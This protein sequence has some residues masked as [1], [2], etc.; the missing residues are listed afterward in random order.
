MEPWVGL[1]DPCCFVKW[2]DA[3]S[4]KW[5]GLT[6]NDDAQCLYDDESGESQGMMRYTMTE[7]R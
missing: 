5:A 2:S 1:D 7:D 4:G 6:P 3:Q